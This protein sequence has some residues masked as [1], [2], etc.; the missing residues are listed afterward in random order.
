MKR[1]VSTRYVPFSNYIA[2]MKKLILMHVWIASTGF[3]SL[4]MDLRAYLGWLQLKPELLHSK[5]LG[6]AN[7][8]W[9]W[10]CKK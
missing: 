10:M 1:L 8:E 7:S 5:T 2:Y 4:C 3:S 9:S 6:G